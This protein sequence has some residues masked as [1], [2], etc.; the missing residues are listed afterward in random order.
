MYTLDPIINLSQT[1]SQSEMLGKNAS[2]LLTLHKLKLNPPS[3]IVITPTAFE[4]FISHNNLQNKLLTMLK[5]ADQHDPHA[6]SQ[7]SSRI[8]KLILT[9]EFEPQLLKKLQTQYHR[10]FNHRYFKLLLS[11]LPHQPVYQPQSSQSLYGDVVFLDHLRKAWADQFTPKAIYHFHDHHHYPIINILI[12]SQHQALVSGKVYTTNPHTQHKSEI[13]IEAIWGNFTPQV[14]FADTYVLDKKSLKLLSQNVVRQDRMLSFNHRIQ[15]KLIQVDAKHKSA[16]KLAM[17]ELKELS[18]KALSLHHQSLMPMEMYFVINQ[19]RELMVTGFKQQENDSLVIENNSPSILISS[20][21]PKSLLTKGLAASPGIVT[22]PVRLVFDQTKAGDVN[23]GEIIITTFASA[24]I[25]PFFRR[26][27]G[28]V[29]ELGGPTSHAAI[30]AREIGCP[31]VTSALKITSLVKTGD[32]ITL[33]GSTGEIFRGGVMNQDSSVKKSFPPHKSTTNL[34]TATKVM[35][36]VS[37]P[38]SI[39]LISGA[40][41]GFGMVRGDIIFAN[42]G[43]HPKHIQSQKLKKEF[44]DYLNSILDKIASANPQE[45]TIYCPANLYSDTYRELTGA[46]HSEPDEMNPLLGY[47]GALRIATDPYIFDIELDVLK[48]LREQGH[49]AN[50]HL[51]IPF[52]RSVKEL[53]LIKRNMIDKGIS[54]SRSNK[55]FIN[56]ETPATI[57]T[58]EKYVNLGIDGVI[59]NSNQLSALTTGIDPNNTE[60]NQFFS[61]NHEAVLKLIRFA[62]DICKQ[63]H[64]PCYLMGQV[65]NPNADI[66]SHIVAWGI[67][68]VIVNPNQVAKVREQLSYAEH[69]RIA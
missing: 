65:L 22:A 23:S 53:D 34:T 39:K 13:Y 46:Y 35:V 2:D 36:T 59:I 18:Q 61:P 67:S 57:L 66:F 6:L 58:L 33:N 50:L 42:F 29:T 56:A 49:H 69:K 11:P 68:G 30:I 32:I 45:P 3:A 41:D 47:H 40:F 15:E 16:P 7:I 31:A 52:I 17:S 37:D 54:R 26:A 63:H 21:N 1:Q 4:Q 60:V 24:K 10:Y 28:I 55:L 62:A 27:S 9:E 51:T 5:N 19:D 38:S 20:P 12:V 48:K 44:K 14:S 43:K 25:L 8:Q 64:L